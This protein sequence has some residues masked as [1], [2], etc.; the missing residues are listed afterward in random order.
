MR[1]RSLSHVSLCYL[2]RRSVSWGV[3]QETT[4]KLIYS[5]NDGGASWQRA[6][7]VGPMNWPQVGVT[8]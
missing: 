4:M 6:A 8:C 1:L 5:S 3:T 7:L 2:G